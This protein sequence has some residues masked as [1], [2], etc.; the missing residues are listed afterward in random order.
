ME[1]PAVRLLY[2]TNLDDTTLAPGGLREFAD[3]MNAID[4]LY[5][6]SPVPPARLAV[7]A[8][9]I[10]RMP[11]ATVALPRHA[12]RLADFGDIDVAVTFLQFVGPIVGL[13]FGMWPC[14]EDRS[15]SGGGVG[16]I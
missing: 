15:K 12:D 2:S 13:A 4:D 14:G 7:A 11:A 10:A 5:E 3:L 1:E 16:S 8:D 6:N 9:S